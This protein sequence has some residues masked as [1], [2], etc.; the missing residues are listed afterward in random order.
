MHIAA[1]RHALASALAGGLALFGAA[2]SESAT[3]AKP[4][5]LNTDCP[6]PESCIE[7]KCRL[8]CR[9]DADCADGQRCDLDDF[10][11]IGGGLGCH[12]R[13]NPCPIG[14]TCGLDGVCVGTLGDQGGGGGGGNLRPPVDSGLAFI[15]SGPGPGGDTGTGPDPRT[16]AGPRPDPDASTPPRDAGP[17]PDPDRGFVNPGDGRYGERCVCSSDCASGFCVENKMRGMRTCTERCDR[18]GDCPDIDTCLMAEVQ[19]GGGGPDCPPFDNGLEPGQVVGVCYPNETSFPCEIPDQC[20]SGICLGQT[21]P[22]PWADPYD[23]CTVQC[24]TNDKCPAGYTC[25]AIPAGNGA[26]LNVCAPAL[27]GVAACR[28]FQECGGVCPVGP[29][30]N[31]VDVVACAQ[32]DANQPGY[33][34]CTCAHATDCPLGYSCHRGL[35]SGDALRPGLCTPIAGYVC[36]TEARGPAPVPMECVSFMC[37]GGDEETPFYSRCTSTCVDDRD[38]PT[39]Y[40]C[41]AVDDGQPGP[42]PRVCVPH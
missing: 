23:V 24:D 33:C 28:S 19:P 37:M 11:C 20:T 30:V 34:T 36:P 32:I 17:R 22:V 18:S 7:G 26:N 2:C 9:R 42:D 8:A 1:L 41:D 21:L 29:G 31:E 12:D 6:V 14:Q 13:D 10:V 15:D 25:Q 5:E 27:A 3:G 39:D 4:C 38:C 40:T 35:E 16:D